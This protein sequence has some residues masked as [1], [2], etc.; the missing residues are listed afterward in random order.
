MERKQSERFTRDELIHWRPDWNSS[1]QAEY[2]K[3]TKDSYECLKMTEPYLDA[4]AH[5]HPSLKILEIGAGTGSS[6]VS[7]LETLLQDGEHETGRP[8]YKTYTFTDVSTGF[9]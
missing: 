4:L 8:K 9:L 3:E 2:Y 1:A 7:V 6:T 5:K